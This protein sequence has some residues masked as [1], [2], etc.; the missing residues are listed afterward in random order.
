MPVPNVSGSTRTTRSDSS[1]FD[2]SGVS[3]RM[4]DVPRNVG[5]P[6]TQAMP[7]PSAC[8][9]SQVSTIDP[10]CVADPWRTGTPLL[11]MEVGTLASGITARMTGSALALA[12][13]GARELVG[14]G[15][16]VVPGEPD[17]LEALLP[18]LGEPVSGLRAV[19]DDGEAAGRAARQHHLPLGVRQ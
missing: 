9:A 16:R 18:R 7:S 5:S 3:D 12:S 17:P 14:R 4:R 19:P 11:R 15:A 2:S 6:M 10:S 1:P 8:A 13:A